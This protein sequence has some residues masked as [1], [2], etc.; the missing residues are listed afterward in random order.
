MLRSDCV[1][2]VKTHIHTHKHPR[3]ARIKQRVQEEQEE[4]RLR[5]VKN[6]EMAAAT[7]EFFYTLM[8]LTKTVKEST[9]AK[10]R[11]ALLKDKVDAIKEKRELREARKAEAVSLK[12]EKL[13]EEEEALDQVF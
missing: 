2:I 3:Y 12:L 11:E 5:L 9:N 13:R 8:E 7:K 10:N 6:H 1:K 4:K